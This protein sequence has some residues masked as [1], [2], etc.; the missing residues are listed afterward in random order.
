MRQSSITL[1]LIVLH[2]MNV[3]SQKPTISVNAGLNFGKWEFGE[4]TAQFDTKFKVGPLTGANTHIPIAPRIAI[5]SELHYTMFGNVYTSGDQHARYRSHYLLLPVMVRYSMDNGISFLS[6]SQSGLLVIAK[7]MRDDERY[8][9]RDAMKKTDFF[10]VFAT[11]Y[12]ATSGVRLGLRYQHGLWDVDKTTE[13]S[14]RNRGF[15]LS[16]SY[17]L[18]SGLRQ[19]MKGIFK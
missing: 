12:R 17:E 16:M 18:S 14:L 5:Q 7:S 11:E 15:S 2:A 3:F 6:G 9:I 19:L 8:N 4:P 10:L 1:I 13:I